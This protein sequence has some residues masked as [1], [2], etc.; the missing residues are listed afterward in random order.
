MEKAVYIEEFEHS[1]VVLQKQEEEETYTCKMITQNHIPGLLPCKIRYDE[2]APYFYYDVTS[3]RSLTKK[4]SDKKMSFEEVS[5]LFYNIGMITKTAAGYL[6][7]SKNF[8]FRPEFLFE[9]LE[10][11]ELFC[12]YYPDKEESEYAQVQYESMRGNYYVLS[13]FLLDK[14]DHR[15]E[16]AVNTAYQFYKMSKEEFFSF[17]AF[18]GFLEKEIRI[19]EE[20]KKEE[21]KQEEALWNPIKSDKPG[22][23]FYQDNKWEDVESNLEEEKADIIKRA[24]LVSGIPFLIGMI[25]CISC[26]AVPMLHAYGKYILIPSITICIFSIIILLFRM[27]KIYFFKRE[28]L[29]EEFEQEVSIDDYFGQVQDGKTVFFDETE[30]TCDTYCLKWEEGGVKKEYTIKSFPV[31]IGKLK[32]STDIII[33]DDSVSRIH[34]KIINRQGK[35]KIQDLNSTNGTFLNGTR[36]HPGKEA[37]LERKDEIRFGKITVNVV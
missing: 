14:I 1:Y 23:E 32:D 29:E 31:T 37:D 16:H 17:E 33:A 30:A 20:E 36:I 35:V 9:D 6:L 13:E 8:L 4:Y 34:A 21:T 27:G 3:K 26:F 10:T 18:L 7:E 15:D 24:F 12:L 28:E 11:E 25:G 19:K 5:E 22:E 2:N